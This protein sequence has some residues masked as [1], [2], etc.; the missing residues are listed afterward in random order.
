MDS[1]QYI[2]YELHRIKNLEELKSYIR[3]RFYLH[4][5]VGTAVVIGK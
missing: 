3:K 5:I 4:H 1:T 2:G